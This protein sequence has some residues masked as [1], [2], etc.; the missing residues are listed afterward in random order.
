MRS[1]AGSVRFERGGGCGSEF[2]E[3]GDCEVGVERADLS[4]KWLQCHTSNVFI[5]V[6]NITIISLYSCRHFSFPLVHSY[7][8]VESKQE[9]V[10]VAV[11]TRALFSGVKG[12]IRML[13]TLLKLAPF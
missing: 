13:F 4:N 9:R 12:S 11:K 2:K 5:A 1:A 8:Y 10:R 7:T 3:G 6:N